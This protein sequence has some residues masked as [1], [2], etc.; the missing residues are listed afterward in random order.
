MILTREIGGWGRD[1]I[2]LVGSFR[3]NGTSDPDDVRDM[4]SNGIASV[5]RG[6]A[7]LFTVTLASPENGGFTAYP[8][9]PF[10]TAEIQQAANPTVW[11]DARVV[12]DSWSQANRTFQVQVL[13][14]TAAGNTAD[15]ASD[16]DDNDVIVFE[17][18]GSISSQGT[19]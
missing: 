17:L 3:I 7:G 6:T 1:V 13:T 18:I 16:A 2:R 19:D 9:K 8:E 5:T 10:I 11:A 4:N 12:R 15:T 14:A